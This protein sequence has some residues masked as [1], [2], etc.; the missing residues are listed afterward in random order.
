MQGNEKDIEKQKLKDKRK[1][2]S[3][4]KRQSIFTKSAKE[5]NQSI[6]MSGK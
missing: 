5:F 2:W 4:D 3:K 6:R 1:S